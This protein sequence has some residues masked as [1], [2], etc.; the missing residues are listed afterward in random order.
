MFKTRMHLPSQGQKGGGP[1]YRA[2]HH[3]S[4]R[5]G[6]RVEL[7]LYY[8][9]QGSRAIG[10]GPSSSSPRSGVKVVYRVRRLGEGK[11]SA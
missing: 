11:E 5:W 10:R 1:A 4:G 7:E 3:L 8:W 2:L 9:P 6:L